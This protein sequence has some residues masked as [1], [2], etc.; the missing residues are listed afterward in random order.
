MDKH[1]ILALGFLFNFRPRQNAHIFLRIRG[2]CGGTINPHE[3]TLNLSM[4]ASVDFLV[5]LWQIYICQFYSVQGECHLFVN[6]LMNKI[7]KDECGHSWLY[8]EWS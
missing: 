5:V 6:L 1:I 3:S 8:C 4:K 7:A 2:K